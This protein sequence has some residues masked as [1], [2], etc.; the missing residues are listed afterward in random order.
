MLGLPHHRP[1]EEHGNESVLLA[2]ASPRRQDLLQAAGIRFEAVASNI[3][4]VMWPGET[5]EQFVRRMAVAKAEKVAAEQ[6][7]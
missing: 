4:E 5:G 2:S 7:R 1:Q 6:A 3:T